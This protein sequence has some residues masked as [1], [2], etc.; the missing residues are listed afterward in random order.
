[1]EW[2]S[3][4]TKLSVQ[5]AARSIAKVICQN[6]PRIYKATAS[7]EINCMASRDVE[8]FRNANNYDKS[9]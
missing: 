5:S 3:K 7:L 1:M 2:H 4:V 8:I 6:N 9:G